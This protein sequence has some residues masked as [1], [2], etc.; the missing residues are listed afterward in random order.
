MLSKTH[1][2]N[3]KKTSLQGVCTCEID[4]RI[5]K[6]RQKRNHK[7]ERG[8]CCFP[9]EKGSMTLEASIILP[10]L[11]LAMTACL[12]FGQMIVVKSAMHHGMVEAAKELAVE[13]YE[14]QES[15][16]IINSFEARLLQSKYAKADQRTPLI[17]LTGLTFA[18][19][20]FPNGQGEIEL[21][22]R[23]RLA[24]SLPFFGRHSMY[25]DECTKQKAF[26]GYE[27]S[28]FEEGKGYAYVTQYGEVYHNNLQC[29]HIMLK[30]SNA[31]D[32]E[33]YTEGETSYRACKKC[34]KEETQTPKVLYVPKEGDCYHASISCSGLT[35]NIR[36]V[37]IWEVENMRPCSRCASTNVE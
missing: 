26:T 22:M 15:G 1:F 13:M 9:F 10:I 4:K 6:C 31:G 18:G 35:R 30:I 33:A 19:S 2:M 14:K 34:I 11:F 20:Q 3:L 12:I 23:Y 28:A 27:P 36:K 37:T 16:S 24:A 8:A 21:H 32:I 25:I 5:K 29:S 17:R 7:W